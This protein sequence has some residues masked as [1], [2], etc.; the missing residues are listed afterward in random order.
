MMAVSVQLF[1]IYYISTL[2]HLGNSCRRK[3]KLIKTGIMRKIM[4]IRILKQR[5]ALYYPKNHGISKLMIWSSQNPAIQSHTPLQEG[6]MI[7]RV[8]SKLFLN[9][10]H[11]VVATQSMIRSREWNMI[12]LAVSLGRDQCSICDFDGTPTFEYEATFGKNWGVGNGM[13][14][15]GHLSPLMQKTRG[16]S[17]YRGEMISVTHLCFRPFLRVPSLHL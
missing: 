17:T 4:F 5:E 10:C 16:F 2:A 1:S 11:S 14:I 8:K 12:N 9:C 6:P 3:D 15:E 13:Q 7:L